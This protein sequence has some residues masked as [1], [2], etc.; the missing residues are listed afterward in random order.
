MEAVTTNLLD[1]PTVEGFVLSA[2]DL[3]LTMLQEARKFTPTTPTHDDLTTL[4]L[5]RT[6]PGD[7]DSV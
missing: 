6:A 1:D 4:A 5:V 2:R 7:D 3:C